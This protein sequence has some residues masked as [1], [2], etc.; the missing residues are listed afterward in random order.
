VRA[1]EPARSEQP[2][3]RRSE[4]DLPSSS[5]GLEARVLTVAQQLAMYRKMSRSKSTPAQVSPSSV[6]ASWSSPVE[7]S[8]CRSCT[9]K[10]LTLNDSSSSG[11]ASVGERSSARKK[12]IRS[13]Q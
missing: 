1:R 5:L 7:R 12:V 4:H 2:H 9:S 3:H 6:F 11:W 10:G 13:S 8:T